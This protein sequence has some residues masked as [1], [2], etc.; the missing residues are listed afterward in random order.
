MCIWRWKDLLKRSVWT[1][2]I[3]II[4]SL[5]NGGWEVLCAA[6]YRWESRKKMIYFQC[7]LASLR[8]WGGNNLIPVQRQPKINVPIQI[9]SSKYTQKEK[10]QKNKNMWILTSPNIFVLFRPW[11]EWHPTTLEKVSYLYWVQRL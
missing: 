9:K 4:G 10:P 11:I 1:D 8:Y 6:I 7:K 3:L 5:D 2:L